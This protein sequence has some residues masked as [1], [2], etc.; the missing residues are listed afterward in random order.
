MDSYR[1]SVGFLMNSDLN[2]Y[3][4]SDEFPFDAKNTSKQYY[5]TIIVLI[6]Y[7]Y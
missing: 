2:S 3:R 5:D 7:K 4:I 1:I 6:Q